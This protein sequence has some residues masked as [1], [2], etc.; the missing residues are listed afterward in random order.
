MNT[1][2]TR[3]FYYK[4]SYICVYQCK[5][6]AKFF[7]LISLHSQRSLRE[8][9]F[10]FHF[11]LISVYQ[12]KSVAKFF[13]LNFLCVHRDLCARSSFYYFPSAFTTISARG[14]LFIISP[15]RSPRSLR[16]VIFLLF[17]LC[18]LSDLCAIIFFF[19]FFS[20]LPSW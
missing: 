6:V 10:F 20:S 16:E 1:D 18:I 14:L 3:I 13:Y 15:L 5:S 2:K 11:Y 7:I 8:T 4:H 17:P 19:F 12:C 9:L